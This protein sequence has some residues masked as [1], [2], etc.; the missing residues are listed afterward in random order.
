MKTS[1]TR[2]AL[3]AIGLPVMACACYAGYFLWPFFAPPSLGGMTI[4][5]ADWRVGLVVEVVDDKTGAPAAEGAALEM[6]EGGYT[7]TQLGRPGSK[8]LGGL[9]ERPGRYELRV[10]KPGYEDWSS[11]VLIQRD[12]CHVITEYK[13]ARL[14]PATATRSGKK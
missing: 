2:L 3:Y 14:T 13:Q 5:T 4:C 7:E 6:V 9:N 12:Q 8:S 11:S 1:K 10:R